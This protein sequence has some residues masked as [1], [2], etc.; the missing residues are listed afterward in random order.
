MNTYNA[1]KNLAARMSPNNNGRYKNLKEYVAQE[2]WQRTGNMK[3]NRAMDD[4]EEYYGLR[5]KRIAP[6]EIMEGYSKV[7]GKMDPDLEELHEAAKQGKYIPTQTAG[8]RSL[9]ARHTKKRSSR[10]SIGR[11]HHTKKYSSRTLKRRRS[12]K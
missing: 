1:E 8:R 7:T 3:K 5:P 12:N 6:S 10:K 9:R 2:G 4:I 11:K